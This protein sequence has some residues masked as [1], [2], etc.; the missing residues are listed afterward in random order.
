VVSDFYENA[1]EAFEKEDIEIPHQ[2][3][4]IHLKK[5]K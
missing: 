5:E 2:Q 1:K 4:D 3:R